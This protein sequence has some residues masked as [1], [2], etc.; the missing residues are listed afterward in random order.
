MDGGLLPPFVL[1]VFAALFAAMRLLGIAYGVY[2]AHWIGAAHPLLGLLA[3][4]ALFK[5]ALVRRARV[6]AWQAPRSPRP[7]NRV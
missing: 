2:E 1:Q 7:D 3:A 6:E 4:I 5:L